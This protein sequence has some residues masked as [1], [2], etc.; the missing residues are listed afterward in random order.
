[1]ES[2]SESSLAEL[3]LPNELSIAVSKILNEKVEYGTE[4]RSNSNSSNLVFHQGEGSNEMSKE[5]SRF[6]D[7]CCAVR[8]SAS[9][10]LRLRVVD[11]LGH[12][13]SH[14]TCLQQESPIHRVERSR[15]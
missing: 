11:A 8:F 10:P 3:P 14:P 4:A 13:V 1:M 7:W 2:N 12:S 9:Y 6:E 5:V 15:S